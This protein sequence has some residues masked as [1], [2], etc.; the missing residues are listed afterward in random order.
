MTIE[1]FLQFI[2]IF[3]HDMRSNIS[4]QILKI[5]LDRDTRKTITDP[6]VVHSLMSIAKNIKELGKLDHEGKQE[7]VGMINRLLN[8]I[9]FGKDLE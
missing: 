1:P 3:P 6:I 8:K 9:N 7:M 2:S 5:Y 4:R